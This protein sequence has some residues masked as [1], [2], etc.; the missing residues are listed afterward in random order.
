MKEKSEPDYDIE[1][2][3]WFKLFKNHYSLHIYNVKVSEKF[4]S[5]DVKPAGE[6]LETLDKLILEGNYLIDQ[7]F[8]IEETF[9]FWKQ[10]PGRTSHP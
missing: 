4:A 6:F 5:A 10:I 9:L 8:N 1:F 3:G 2:T 7:I